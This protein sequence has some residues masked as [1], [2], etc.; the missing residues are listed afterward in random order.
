MWIFGRLNGGGIKWID[1]SQ[2]R[3]R[4]WAL[5][6]AVMNLRFHKVRGK[7]LSS[8]GRV[9]FPRRTLLQRVSFI[10]YK[11]TSICATLVDGNINVECR[12]I[13]LNRV[14]FQML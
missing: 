5:V 2:D 7:F 13:R 10:V 6:N 9:S 4:W 11:F 14:L 1:L 12:E 8:L 3:D